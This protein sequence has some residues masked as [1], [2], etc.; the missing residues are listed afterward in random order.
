VNR[1]TFLLRG[2]PKPPFGLRRVSFLALLA[3]LSVTILPALA[4]AQKDDGSAGVVLRS[5][6]T[7]KEVGLPIYPGARPHKDKSGDT[8]ATQLGLWGGAFS[9]KL[10][11]LKLES[12]DAPEKVA[13]FYRKALGKYG[14][15]L[16]CSAPSP[17]TGEKGKSSS[18]K[19]L[20]CGD[21]KPEKGGML[22]KAGTKEKL[23]IVAIQSNGKGSVFQLIY[24]E[25]RGGDN[26]QQPL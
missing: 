19:Q 8:P 12:A 6:A 7:A 11:V 18:S 24:V 21:D 10:V 17:T 25:A 2:I 26:D 23:H 3:M 9:F 16:D 15:L 14:T 4:Q 22:F 13:E 5:Q 1:D 20:E